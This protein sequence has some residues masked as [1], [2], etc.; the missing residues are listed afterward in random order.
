[1]FAQWV[2]Q[3]GVLKYIVGNISLDLTE[4]KNE[5]YIGLIMSIVE[6]LSNAV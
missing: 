3:N 5:L 6:S 2:N 1:M 4:L